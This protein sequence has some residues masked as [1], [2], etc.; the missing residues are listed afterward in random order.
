MEGNE[1]GKRNKSKKVDELMKLRERKGRLGEK[2]VVLLKPYE[3]CCKMCF[4][5]Y[6]RVV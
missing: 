5:Y 4:L 1:R 3:S 6:Y 2:C